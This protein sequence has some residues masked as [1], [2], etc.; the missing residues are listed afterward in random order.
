[1]ILGLLPPSSSVTRFTVPAASRM[2]HWPTSVEPVKA[3]LSTSGWRTS[4]APAVAP[5]PG[6]TL[7]APG[8]KPAASAISPSSRAV[9]GVSCAG[10]STT[11]Q[12]AASAGATFQ[13]ARLRGKFH[14]TI[15]PTTPTGSRSVY[16]KKLPLTGSVSPVSLSAQ[17]A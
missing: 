17:P 3:I 11:V 2:I 4:A 10:L 12:P 5:G 8:G 14:G 9:R 1:M 16:V 7:S 15:A 6:T 13:Q